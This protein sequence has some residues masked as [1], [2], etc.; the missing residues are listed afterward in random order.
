M[1]VPV[2]GFGV[3]FRGPELTSW[4]DAPVEVRDMIFVLGRVEDVPCGCRACLDLQAQ[5]I[6]LGLTRSRYY[7]QG[8][9]SEEALAI[10]A[11]IDASYF[12]GPLPMNSA[13]PHHTVEW[14]GLYFPLAPAMPATEGE[15]EVNEIGPATTDGTTTTP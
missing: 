7:I 2:F 12:V 11:A 1:G 14:N 6:D 3:G 8:L 10:E 15:T 5:G 4:P 9:F 13:L